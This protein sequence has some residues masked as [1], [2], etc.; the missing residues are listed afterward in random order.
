[1]SVLWAA[2]WPRVRPRPA[3]GYSPRPHPAPR[4]RVW[5]RP[6]PPHQGILRTI[7]LVLPRRGAPLRGALSVCRVLESAVCRCSTAVPRTPTPSTAT[8]R[9]AA[10]LTDTHRQTHSPTH[11]YTHSH[12]LTHAHL[13]AH[14]YRHTHAHLH[15]HTYTL[16]LIHSRT[17]VHTLSHAHAQAHTI[18]THLR[19]HPGALPCLLGTDVLHLCATDTAG[20]VHLRGAYLYWRVCGPTNRCAR[21][22]D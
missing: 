5:R 1:M 6:S 20:C 13:H 21:C 19:T 11:T 12:A 2:R 17:H 10:I 22:R 9:Y 4:S 16:T 3:R 7:G 8:Q 15:T 14:I 18:R